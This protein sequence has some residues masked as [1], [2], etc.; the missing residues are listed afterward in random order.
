MKGYEAG[1]FVL[2]SIYNCLAGA[3]QQF[4]YAAVRN[5]LVRDRIMVEFVAQNYVSI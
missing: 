1:R 4:Y 3:S 2:S 5:E